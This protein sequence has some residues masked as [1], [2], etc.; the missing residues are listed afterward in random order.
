MPTNPSSSQ[1]PPGPKYQV[2]TPEAAKLRSQFGS[3]PSPPPPPSST[4]PP[5]AQPA[6][7]PP[8][9]PFSLFSHFRSRYATLP[10]PVRTGL[11]VLRIL[12]PIVPIGLFFSEHVL[13]VMW[14]SG[15]SMTPYLNEDYEQMHTKRDMVLVNMWPWGGAGWPWERTR[16]LER[17][18]V[19]TFRSPANPGHIAIKR[20]VGLP[21]DRITTRDPCMK[22]SQ[23]VP[24][25]HVWLE[26]DAAD[27]KR[28]LDS[29][30]YGPVSISLI[31]GRVMA[32]MYPRFRMLKWT[33]WEQGLVEG[34]VERK[35]GDNYRHEVRD[36]VSK[37]AVKLERP[38]LS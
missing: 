38:V 11:R 33:D 6:P 32:V 20:V 8:R 2:L 14:V 19:V 31:T 26:G 4:A 36:R 35:L 34:D 9:K 29:N 3:S 10:V 5:L 28:S 17:G 27:P 21:G 12:A 22:P 37:E 1:K 25:N 24:F 15:P 30:T 18:M 7:E 13:G 16:R 23:I